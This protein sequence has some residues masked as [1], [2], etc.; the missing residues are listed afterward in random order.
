M[1]PPDLHPAEPHPPCPG[2]PRG[3]DADRALE[4]GLEIFRRHGYE[5]TS[6]DALTQ[7]MGISRSSLYACFGSKRGVLIAALARYSRT[8]LAGLAALAEAAG[9]PQARVRAMLHSLA[10]PQAGPYGCLL[11]N[12]ITELAP[13]DPEVAALGRRHLAAIEA[14]IARRLA[15]ADPE[16]ATAQAG[17]LMA[18]ALGTISLRKS[19]MDPAR[20]SATLAQADALMHP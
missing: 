20:L 17:A 9:T 2:R 14:L 3:F 6:L 7:A 5:A 1:T 12:C 13:H 19:G 4:A 16:A 18:L 10:A 11:V 8:G 15:P